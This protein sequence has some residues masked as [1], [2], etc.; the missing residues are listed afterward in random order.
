MKITFLAHT[1]FCQYFAVFARILHMS[2]VVEPKFWN[3]NYFSFYYYMNTWSKKCI[4]CRMFN[5]LIVCSD[6][7]FFGCSSETVW[8]VYE[9]C[10]P[11][12]IM[13]VRP[14]KPM[15]RTDVRTSS[16]R[17]TTLF[18]SWFLLG[19]TRKWSFSI[20]SFTFFV[21]IFFV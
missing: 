6:T 2:R 4:F 14:M 17:L 18:M 9:I 13:S 5:L 10:L 3:N 7:F 8:N 15:F 19:Q 12:R 21:L 1:L 16:V 11:V 20:T